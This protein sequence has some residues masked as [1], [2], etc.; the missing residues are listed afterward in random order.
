MNTQHQERQPQKGTKIIDFLGN[1][2]VAVE[3]DFESFTEEFKQ[4][5][6]S[7]KLIQYLE[8]FVDSSLVDKDSCP[9]EACVVSGFDTNKAMF[10]MGARQVIMLLKHILEK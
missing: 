8:A 9:K 5:P 6:F 2:S 3:K 4:S 7:P 10:L 1:P